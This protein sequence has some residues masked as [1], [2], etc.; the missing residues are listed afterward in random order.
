MIARIR[1]SLRSFWD[2]FLRG[3]G[4]TP[5]VPPDAQRT[6]WVRACPCGGCMTLMLSREAPRIA[7]FLCDQCGEREFL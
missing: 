5:P 3:L 6:P 7:V 2:G 1:A 4:K